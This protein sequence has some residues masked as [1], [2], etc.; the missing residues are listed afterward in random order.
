[1][2]VILIQGRSVKQTTDGGYI[3]N[4]TESYGNGNRDYWLNQNRC[5][6]VGNRM[7]SNVWWIL[8]DV[9]SQSTNHRCW[10]II[11]GYQKIITNGGLDVWLIKTDD[12]GNEEWDQTFGS[13]DEGNQ[14]FWNKLRWWIY[15]ANEMNLMVTQ[16]NVWVNQIRSTR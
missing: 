14:S 11:A 16:E 10:I 13:D 1:M 4:Q 8:D 15:S 12:Q 9:S 5:S 7:E 2:V 6:K 3:I